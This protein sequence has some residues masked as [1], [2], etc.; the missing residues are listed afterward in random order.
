L[1]LTD[2]YILCYEVAGR[3]ITRRLIGVY[4]QCYGQ[5]GRCL[6]GSITGKLIGVYIRIITERLIGVYIASI[7]GRLYMSVWTVLLEAD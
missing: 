5:P 1:K 4:T 2:V 3:H 6:Y 7:I